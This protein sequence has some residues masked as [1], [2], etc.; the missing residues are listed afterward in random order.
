MNNTLVIKSS[1]IRLTI[2][3]GPDFIEFDPDDTLFMEGFYNLIEEF[4]RKQEQYQT[5]LDVKQ[6]QTNE[7][8]LPL[9]ARESIQALKE[10]CE[11][12]H[13]QVDL[14][15]GAGSSKKLFGE[16][17]SFSPIQQFFE[18]ITPYIRSARSKKL[19]KYMPPKTRKR[20]SNKPAN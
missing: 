2:N 4:T 15:L 1:V 8:G 14:M 19:D 16:R 13:V 18:G 10:I 12:T 3:E 20:R 17:L 5:V 9:H 6:D 7:V 11:F